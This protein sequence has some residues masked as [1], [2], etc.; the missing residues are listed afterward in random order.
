M[1][2]SEQFCS[3]LESSPATD[4]GTVLSDLCLDHEFNNITYYSSAIPTGEDDE[5][6]LIT[7]YPQAWV[8]HYFERE[9]EVIDLNRAGFA[10][11]SNS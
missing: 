3:R 10:G 2:L 6:V 9:Y 8:T 1:S 11:G 4:L 7:T 5:T